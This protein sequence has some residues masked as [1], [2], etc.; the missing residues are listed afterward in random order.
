MATCC[1]AFR[2]L[3]HRILGLST[4]STAED[5][6]GLPTISGGSAKTRRRTKR[7][8][9]HPLDVTVDEFELG[10]QDAHRVYGAAVS[11]IDE[12]GVL[13]SRSGASENGGF[14][15][16]EPDGTRSEEAIIKWDISRTGPSG[17]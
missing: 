14:Y 12:R 8:K 16:A 7:R 4:I 5:T 11:T 13:E 9:E 1:V 17:R 10:A 15:S 3:V 2:P 6:Y